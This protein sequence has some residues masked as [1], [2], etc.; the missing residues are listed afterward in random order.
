MKGCSI[1]ELSG[2]VEPIGTDLFV[3]E[4]AENRVRRLTHG[5]RL[6]EPATPS[7][8]WAVASQLKDGERLVRIDSNGKLSHCP[9][10][11]P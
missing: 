1:R 3:W 9:G 8:T 7:G 6:R 10:A 11:R 5:A 2:R 4:R